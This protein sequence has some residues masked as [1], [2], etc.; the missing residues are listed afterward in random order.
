MTLT[1][2]KDLKFNVS[3]TVVAWDRPSDSV[4]FSRHINSTIENFTMKC[5]EEQFINR[6]EQMRKMPDR[7]FSYIYELNKG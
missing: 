4:Y 7:D 5:T 1:L 6:L 3:E 2:P